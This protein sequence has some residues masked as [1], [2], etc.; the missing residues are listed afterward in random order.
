MSYLEN[1]F[2]H[3]NAALVSCLVD[4]DSFLVNKD[5]AGHIQGV[6]YLSQS[7]DFMLW[8]V[9]LLGYHVCLQCPNYKAKYPLG[10][11]VEI[12]AISLMVVMMSVSQNTASSGQVVV[13]YSFFFQVWEFVLWRQQ[14]FP[15]FTE[16]GAALVRQDVG[17]LYCYEYMTCCRGIFTSI[18][19]NHTVLG[20]W[21]DSRVQYKVTQK[22]RYFTSHN[23]RT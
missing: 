4:Y 2:Q 1:L 19:L 20:A 23:R 21:R 12:H 6:W 7:R 13:I 16:D 18:C 3:L 10:S 8:E 15:R 22:P 5:Y 17:H 14:S 9:Q 11:A